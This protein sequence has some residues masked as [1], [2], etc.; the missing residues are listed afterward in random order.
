MTRIN[1]NRMQ[2]V[3]YRLKNYKPIL[4]FSLFVSVLI[5]M[6]SILQPS[7]SAFLF[8]Q[9][10]SLVLRNFLHAVEQK[11]GIDPQ[12]FWQFREEYSPGSFHFNEQVADVAGVLN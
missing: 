6:F 3:Y 4:L 12:D 11:N 10:R 5:G 8:P 2:Q 7:V 1:E 9:K